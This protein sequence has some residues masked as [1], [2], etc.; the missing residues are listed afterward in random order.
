MEF[1]AVQL[2]PPQGALRTQP[3]YLGSASMSLGIWGGRGECGLIS[4]QQSRHTC[5]QAGAQVTVTGSD[6]P[7]PP[8]RSPL[9]ELLRGLHQ[10][11]VVG[12]VWHSPPAR[13]PRQCA[14]PPPLCQK[15]VS[16]A[17]CALD[18]AVDE[19]AAD[20]EEGMRR[21]KEFRDPAF[22]PAPAMPDPENQSGLHPLRLPPRPGES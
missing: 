7:A 20:I 13:S 5:S 3:W 10:G 16:A 18:R 22:R 1:G 14:P 11:L 17:W 15:A 4:P 2:V 12:G 9:A 8:Q 6:S 19:L 21:E